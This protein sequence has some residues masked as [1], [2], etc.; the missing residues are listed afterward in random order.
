MG[1]LQ[2]RNL[3]ATR[4]NLHTNNNR[5]QAATSTTGM[6]FPGMIDHQTP[7]FRNTTQ[8]FI[9]ASQKPSITDTLLSPIFASVLAGSREQESSDSGTA[10][11]GHVTAAANQQSHPNEFASMEDGGG[12]RGLNLQEN[13]S[14]IDGTGPK[15]PQVGINHQPSTTISTLSSGTGVASQ[16]KSGG[17]ATSSAVAAAAST[18]LPSFNAT[19]PTKN[20]KQREE[21]VKNKITFELA[22]SRKRQQLESSVFQGQNNHDDSRK[23][24]K[25]GG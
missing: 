7:D 12:K 4:A 25:Q 19:A 14:S 24:K 11:G 3:G 17:L 15:S 10:T 16:H 1:R 18:L 9:A 23:E 22:K 13:Q 2:R 20:A 5:L 6:Y 8:D 21:A